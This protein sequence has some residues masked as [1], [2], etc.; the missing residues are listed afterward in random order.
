MIGY[1]ILEEKES[2]FNGHLKVVRSWG[3]GTYIQAEGLTQSGGIVET[4]WKQSLKRIYNPQFTITNCLILGL[5]GGTV[6]KL[7]KK[8]WKDT[9]VIGV[10]ID[11][12]MIELG[13]KYLKFD[14]S[15]IEVQMGDALQICKKL[16]ARGAKFDLIIIDLYNG[17]QFPKKFEKEDFIRLT[18]M[19]LSEDGV[20]MFNRL[21]YKDKKVEAEK[22]GRKLQKV[23][24]KVEYYRPVSN[25]M[26]ICGD[27]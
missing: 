14:K 5:G 22:F 8:N 24:R 7:V 27:F 17:D 1:K 9:K 10:D 12:L 21:Y 20:A 2:K 18:K 11:P 3:L 25:L 15:Q 4:F 6:A 16:K 26:F 23:F 19:M 13:E